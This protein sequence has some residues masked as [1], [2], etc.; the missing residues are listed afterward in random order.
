M[1]LD[2][3]LPFE[4]LLGAKTRQFE[5]LEGQEHSGEAVNH[6]GVAARVGLEHLRVQVDGC[7]EALGLLDTA[8]A[9][10]KRAAW[11][12]VDAMKAKAMHEERVALEQ[13]VA[14]A[15][16]RLVREVGRFLLCLDP[17]GMDLN[18]AFH[19][20]QLRDIASAGRLRRAHALVGYPEWPATMVTEIRQ[21]IESLTTNQM[22]NVVIGSPLE[23]ALEDPRWLAAATLR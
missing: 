22:K 23:A 7:R 12:A 4:T 20:Q 17:D 6:F 21:E 5:L 15:K 9:H 2:P 11:E 18:V 1:A 10:A 8:E 14:A 3:L 16:L 19:A 13:Q